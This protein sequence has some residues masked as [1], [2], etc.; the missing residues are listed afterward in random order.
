M[1]NDFKKYMTYLFGLFI[2]AILL[3]SVVLPAGSDA[4][5]SGSDA[6]GGYVS[7]KLALC[8]PATP[9]HTSQNTK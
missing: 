9:A 8:D 7:C 1:S 2:V 3:I 5:K 6:A 4:V